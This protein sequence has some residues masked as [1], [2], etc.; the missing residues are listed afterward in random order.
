MCP[1]K[2]WGKYWEDLK[3]TSHV[4]QWP[5]MTQNNSK[6]LKKIINCDSCLMKLSFKLWQKLKKFP[7]KRHCHFRR[8]M[9]TTNGIDNRGK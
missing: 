4:G 9:I 3:F 8:Q 2:G 5:E 1:W 7:S 6:V